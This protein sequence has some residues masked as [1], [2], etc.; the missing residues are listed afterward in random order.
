MVFVVFD[1]VVEQFRQLLIK[2]H[3]VLG[4]VIMMMIGG[5]GLSSFLF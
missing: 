4:S 3:F 1:P 2:R 5:H